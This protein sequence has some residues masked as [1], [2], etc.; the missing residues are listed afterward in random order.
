[1]KQSMELAFC[2]C[3]AFA[4]ARPRFIS[5]DPSTFL[6]PVP[7]GSILYLTAEVVYTE[8]AGDDGTRVHVRVETKVRDV[9]HGKVT[10][11]GV[12]NYTFYT[13]KRLDV[14]PVTYAEFVSAL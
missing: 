14:M 2:C 13:D 7:V 3:S 6:A 9:E 8:A 10:D 4:H 11:T 1:M 12:F 5:L